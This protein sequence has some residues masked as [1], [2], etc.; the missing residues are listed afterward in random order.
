MVMSFKSTQLRTEI[1]PSTVNKS[2][3]V[4]KAAVFFKL[5]EKIIHMIIHLIESEKHKLK[6]H[7]IVLNYA[8]CKP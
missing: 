8:F 1:G 4:L 5:N 6:K 7:S 2:Y 3:H